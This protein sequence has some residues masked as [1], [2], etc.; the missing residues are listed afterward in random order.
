MIAITALCRKPLI[1]LGHSRSE[2]EVCHG[3]SVSEAWGY[4]SIRGLWEIQ[5][6]AIIGVRF[7]DT[8]TDILNLEGINK[9]FS[10]WEK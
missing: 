5:T 10:W 4:V 7:G 1:H 6:E 2:E 9:L 3:G 8:D